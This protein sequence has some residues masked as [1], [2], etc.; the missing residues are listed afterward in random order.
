MKETRNRKPTVRAHLTMLWSLQQSQ[1]MVANVGPTIARRL[2]QLR[3]EKSPLGSAAAG[4]HPVEG[5]DIL[6]QA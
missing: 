5:A 2:S 3:K 1:A 4:A 6:L